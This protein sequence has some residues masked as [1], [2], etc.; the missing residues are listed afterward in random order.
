M[1]SITHIALGACVGELVL[2]KKLGKK[3]LFWG[4]LSQCLPDIDTVVAALYPAGQ[5]FLIHRG[6]THSLLFAFVIGLFLA[7][8]VQKIHRKMSPAF[9]LLAFFFCFQLLLHDLL[10]T[11]NSYGTGLLEPFSHRRFSIHLLYVVDPFFSISFIVASSF[12]VFKS[13]GNKNR[14]TW[15]GLAAAVSACYLV[16]AV[17]NKTYIHHRAE[18]SFQA[19]KLTPNRYFSTPA[20]FNCM[21]WY[22]VAD[23]DSSYYTG[24]TSIFDDSR[25]TIV[26]EQ[27]PKNYQLLN[28]AADSK[29]AHNLVT[30]A[31]GYYTLS[32]AGGIVFLNVLRFEQIRGWERDNAPFV[33]SY[34]LSSNNKQVL[35]LQ[36]GRMAG[37]NKN[38]FGDYLKRIFGASQKPAGRNNQSL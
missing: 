25:N 20:P 32:Q 22:V 13:S 15:S 12:L 29:S 6:I 14:S 35:L 11:C 8:V 9:S 27:H 1:D 34:P 19:Q 28:N 21:L 3:A 30:F 23:M 16:I 2:G 24:Y 5:A 38:S 17:V 36:R 31:D 18:L 4:A 7:F 37:W 10:D 33:F 26:F